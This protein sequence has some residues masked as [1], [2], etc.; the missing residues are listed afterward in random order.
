MNRTL[1]DPR[2]CILYIV[3]YLIIHIG[4]IVATLGTFDT[5]HLV[6][7]KKTRE[8]GGGGGGKDV[9]EE[10]SKLDR[11]AERE[12]GRWEYGEVGVGLY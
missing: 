6:H 4:L 11:H 9:S 7:E 1:G 5:K 10:T 2:L 8:V 3:T 12:W